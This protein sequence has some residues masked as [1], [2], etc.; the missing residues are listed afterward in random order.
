MWG[1]NFSIPIS[2]VPWNPMIFLCG[3]EKFNQD[4]TPLRETTCIQRKMIFREKF[5]LTH[6]TI[7]DM[8]VELFGSITQSGLSE[9]PETDDPPT[10]RRA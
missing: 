7:C 2:K 6:L 9:R 5:Q 8:G 10:K 3:A 4:A 1:E